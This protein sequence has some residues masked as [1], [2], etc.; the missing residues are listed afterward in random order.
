MLRSPKFFARL[1]LRGGMNKTLL[2]MRPGHRDKVAQV[3]TGLAGA[4]VKAR[5]CRRDALEGFRKR[6]CIPLVSRHVIGAVCVDIA[7]ISG[8][9]IWVHPEEVPI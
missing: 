6:V 9:Q 5:V 8:P 4:G 3:P 1:A 7:S 2:P